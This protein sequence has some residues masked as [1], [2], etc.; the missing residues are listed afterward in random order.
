M[1]LRKQVVRA[2]TAVLVAWAV[3]A[4]PAGALASGLGSGV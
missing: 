3:L 4:F 2:L 1:N